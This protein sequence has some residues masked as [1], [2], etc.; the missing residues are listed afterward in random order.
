MFNLHDYLKN[1]KSK[2]KHIQE[3]W[4]A[5]ILVW[6]LTKQL[7]DW[8]KSKKYD[9]C[10]HVIDWISSRTRNMPIS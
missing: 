3:V 9:E 5:P 4:F 2:L 10:V 7:F 1:Y 6:K 8:K